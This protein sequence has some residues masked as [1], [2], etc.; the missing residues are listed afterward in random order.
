M[1][2]VIVFILGAVSGIVFT[3]ILLHFLGN[4]NKRNSL[5]DTGINSSTKN[6]NLPKNDINLLNDK[7]PNE[8]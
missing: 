2:Y 1:L 3:L 8:Q 7:F 5:N 6:S 4:S